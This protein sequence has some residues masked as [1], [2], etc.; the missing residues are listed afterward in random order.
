MQSIV[1]AIEDGNESVDAWCLQEPWATEEE[2]KVVE[3]KLAQLGCHG[4]WQ[5]GDVSK[6]DQ[7]EESQKSG[8]GCA[9]E[10]HWSRYA[11][12]ERTVGS[13]VGGSRDTRGGWRCVSTLR[14]E[15][16]KGLRSLVPEACI[17]LNVGGGAD[18]SAAGDW[19]GEPRADV[20]VCWAHHGLRAVSCS[21]PEHI[22]AR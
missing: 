15:K 6:G 11:R 1:Q 10:E 12:P 20:V 21:D 7:G 13:T 8:R 2:T 19:N 14:L 5:M 18:M 17:Q 4:Y 9:G 22:A 3:L 16:G